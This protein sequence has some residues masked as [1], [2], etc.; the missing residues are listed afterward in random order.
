LYA[1]GSQST[2]DEPDEQPM[3][4]RKRSLIS[5]SFNRS[6]R[7]EGRSQLL[8]ANAGA[9]I[10]R[11]AHDLLTK[12]GRCLPRLCRR[13]RKFRID[14]SDAKILRTLVSLRTQ[15][16]ERLS[17]VDRLRDDPVL[18]VACSDHRGERAADDRLPSKSTLSRG[19]R[20]LASKQRLEWM[21]ELLVEQAAQAVK[22]EGCK[23]RTVTLDIDSTSIESYGLLGGA[24]YSGHYR[25]RCFHPLFIMLGDEGHLLAADLRPGNVSSNHG[26]VELL[27][28]TIARVEQSIASVGLIRGDSGFMSPK[29]L[30]AL[31]GLKKPPAYIFRLNSNSK[32][33]RLGIPSLERPSSPRTKEPREWLTEIDYKAA[34]WKK[35]RRVIIV[36]IERPGE[37]FVHQFYLVTNSTL[38]AER[39]L[40]LYRQRGT[41]EARLGEW[42]SAVPPTLSCTSRVRGLKRDRHLGAAFAANR[43]ALMVSALAYNTLHLLRRLSGKPSRKKHGDGGISLMR[44]RRTLLAVAGRVVRSGRRLTL[45]VP[46]DDAI[47]LGR[48]VQKLERGLELAAA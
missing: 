35:A 22:A 47:A 42:K 10:V 34:R 32:L 36:N 31:E 37:L 25:T 19:L 1:A 29:I 39:V 15:G 20:R 38:A 21:E 26:A 33:A 8:T 17:D 11:Q 2:A 45:M 30:E 43:V 28:R 12:A 40:A 24:A 5:F 4:E 16:Y 41:A 48:V 7:M 46:S 27:T 13:R 9:V 6:V 3:G 44:T 23:L 18:R 14:H